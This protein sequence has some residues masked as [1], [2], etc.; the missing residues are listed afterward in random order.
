MSFHLVSVPETRG[1]SP[2]RHVWFQYEFQYEF[3]SIPT[4]IRLDYPS[5][6]FPFAHLHLQFNFRIIFIIQKVPNHPINHLSGIMNFFP[7]H[8]GISNDFFSIG[9]LL[10]LFIYIMNGH[11][12]DRPFTPRYYYIHCIAACFS[13]FAH[14]STLLPVQL[15]LLLMYF[16]LSFSPSLSTRH[17]PSRWC[18]CACVGTQTRAMMTLATRLITQFSLL[19][20]SVSHVS[21]CVE[22][23]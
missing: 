10:L 13:S 5:K 22:N 11:L 20:L 7:N 8:R 4:L 21:I 1:L 9:K 16:L 3:Q 12:Y 19:Y 15:L 2:R 18:N 14:S 23:N 6:F 17:S